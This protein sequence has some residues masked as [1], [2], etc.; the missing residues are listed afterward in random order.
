MAEANLAMERSIL[1]AT[2]SRSL[3]L[4]VN[5]TLKQLGRKVYVL[6]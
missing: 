3:E 6:L 4:E 1:A 5:M 2:H